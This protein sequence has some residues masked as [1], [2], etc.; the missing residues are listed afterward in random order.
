[1]GGY[2]AVSWVV[3]DFFPFSTFAMYS[4]REASAS[5]VVARDARGQVAEIDRFRSWRCEGPIELGSEACAGEP[6]FSTVMYKDRE[7]AEYIASHGGDDPSAAPVDVVRRI[8]WLG[9][10]AG[11]PRSHDCLIQRCV[12]VAR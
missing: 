11:A 9:A 2:L 4:T 8:W 3:R 10:E 7:A 5:R 1:M 12:A 6:H